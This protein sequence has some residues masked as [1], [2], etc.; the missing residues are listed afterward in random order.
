MDKNIIKILGT[1]F[2][3]GYNDEKAISAVGLK[4]MVEMTLSLHS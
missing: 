2:D 1:L 3:N 4:E